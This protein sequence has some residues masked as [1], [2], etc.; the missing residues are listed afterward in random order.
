MIDSR[1][2]DCFRQNRHMPPPIIRPPLRET[3]R[4]SGNTAIVNLLEAG[5]QALDQLTEQAKNHVKKNIVEAV[6]GRPAKQIGGRK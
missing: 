4:E 1:S 2:S 5:F 3:L 6:T